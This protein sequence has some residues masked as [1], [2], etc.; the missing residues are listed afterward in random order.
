M[1]PSQIALRSRGLTVLGGK[2]VLITAIRAPKRHSIQTGARAVALFAAQWFWRTSIPLDTPVCTK[3]L[4]S[5]VA[6]MKSA[7]DGK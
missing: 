6:V 2:N 3:N 5:G 7:Q 4:S 1:Q